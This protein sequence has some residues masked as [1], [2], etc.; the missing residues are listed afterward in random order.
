MWPNVAFQAL[1]SLQ[2]GPRAGLSVM[3][4]RDKGDWPD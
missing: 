2:E 4:V 1:A 3:N